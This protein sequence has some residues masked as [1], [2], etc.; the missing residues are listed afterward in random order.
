MRFRAHP[1]VLTCVWL[2]TYACVIF[3]SKYWVFSK[4]N[5]CLRL[6]Q[7]PA[8][9]RVAQNQCCWKIMLIVVCNEI[10]FLL[11]TQQSS[12]DDDVIVH[13]VDDNDNDGEL[14]DEP[15]FQHDRF[16]FISLTMNFMSST[17]YTSCTLLVHWRAVFEKIEFSVSC[18]SD[19]VCWS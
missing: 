19:E 18:C 13:N 16:D 12:V 8:Q 7:F 15:F 3:F 1:M 11:M 9:A 5:N 17:I 6:L 10:N 14:E 4:Q 2:C